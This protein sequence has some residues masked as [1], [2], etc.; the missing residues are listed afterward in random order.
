MPVYFICGY[1]ITNPSLLTEYRARVD[2]TV[3][4][5]GGH[6]VSVSYDGTTLEGTP[7]PALIVLQFDSADAILAWYHSADYQAILPL[8]REAT[9]DAWAMITDKHP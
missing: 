9:A 8:R 2:D 7:P 6:Y 3:A 4:Q 5:Y 1:R